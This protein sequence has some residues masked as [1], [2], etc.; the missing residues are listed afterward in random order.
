[1]PEIV[2]PGDALGVCEEFVAGPGTF[3][4]NG[5]IYSLFFGVAQRDEQG[6]KIS[7]LARKQVRAFKEG[8]LVYGVV[9]QLYEAMTMVRFT[10]ILSGNEVPAGDNTAF[11]R[12]S[13]LQNGYVEQLR[14]CIRT[15]DIV[16]ARVLVVSPLAT[17]LTLKERDLGVVKALCSMCR[18]EMKASQGGFFTCPYC[19][20]REPRKTPSSGEESGEDSY[21]REGG[22]ERGR[23][24]FG[25]RRSGGRDGGERRGG[26]DG[27]RGR[28]E[29]RSGGYG[30][31]DGGRSSGSRDGRNG[32]SGFNNRGGGR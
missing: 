30:S 2:N 27:A 6:R 31:R 12:I 11:I 19:G 13:E 22:N 20:S 14:D 18:A 21:E 23:S 32:N 9:Q 4:E 15:G 26:F 3:E 28:G 24:S 1:M 16:K 8:D 7:V 10:P 29:G 5:K 25:G 17:Y